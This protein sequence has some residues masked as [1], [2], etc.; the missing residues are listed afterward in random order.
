M[1]R[2]ILLIF[3]GL[4]VIAA[5]FPTNADPAADRLAAAKTVALG[6][7]KDVRGIKAIESVRLKGLLPKADLFCVEVINPLEQFSRR[8]TFLHTLIMTP[9]GNTFIETDE[10]ACGA[11]SKSGLKPVDVV[12]VVNTSLAFGELRNYVLEM[13]VAPRI[14]PG[15]WDVVVKAGENGWIVNCVFM[16]DP[17]G[18]PMGQCDRYEIAIS[19]DGRISAKAV[20]TLISPLYD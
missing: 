19:R 1:K 17:N 13:P 9:D 15:S 3:L 6:R 7:W 2:A 4:T 11:L 12:D 8:P 5:P 16:I 10:A 14:H 20:E 18:G